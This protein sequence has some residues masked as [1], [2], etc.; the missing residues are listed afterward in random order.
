MNLSPCPCGSGL[1]YAACCRPYHRGA[2]TPDTAEKLM[3][4]RYSAFFLKLEDHLMQTWHSSMRPAKL[5]LRDDDTNWQ[6]LEIL[7]R[8]A[9]GSTDTR[10][11][12][13]F[14]AYY[15]MPD[16]I[17]YLHEI[18]NFIRENG[19]WFYVDG[20]IKPMRRQQSA[21]QPPA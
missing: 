9:G 16:G 8:H 15:L 10:G 12:V 2:D 13:E 18:S 1:I 4:S 7:K 5:D 19:V 17:G 3:R 6:K 21:S 11:K 20:K 14:K